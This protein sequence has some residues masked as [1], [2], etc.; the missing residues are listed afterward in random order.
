[1]DPEN[2]GH[3]F[4]SKQSCLASERYGIGQI[5]VWEFLGF[6]FLQSIKVAAFATT[7]KIAANAA[8]TMIFFI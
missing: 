5:E 2:S 3:P 6:L 1:L 7:G 4:T 8:V